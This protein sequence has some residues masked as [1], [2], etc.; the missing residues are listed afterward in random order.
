MDADWQWYALA[1]KTA[2]LITSDPLV[3]KTMNQWRTV[4]K[5]GWT[6]QGLDD[7]SS[8]KHFMAGN[9]AMLV[10]GSWVSAMIANA[11]ANVKDNVRIARVPFKY[12][13]SGPQQRNSDFSEYQPGAKGSSLGVYQAAH[14][15]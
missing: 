5:K 11:A 3:E 14:Y 9:A 15:A 7:V 2:N 10:D 6:P 8:R 12:I 13:P 4:A 1:I